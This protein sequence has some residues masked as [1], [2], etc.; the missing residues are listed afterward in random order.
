MTDALYHSDP[1]EALSRLSSE[2]ME[3]LFA[4]AI[5]NELF[6]EPG[7]TVFGIAQRIKCLPEGSK[8]L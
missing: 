1:L 5:V 4:G 3:E 8:S 7:D 2:D 6:L